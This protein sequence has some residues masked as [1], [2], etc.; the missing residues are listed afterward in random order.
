MSLQPGTVI[1]AQVQQSLATARCRSRAAAVDRRGCRFRCRP[2]K[3]CSYRFR[4]R[5]TAASSSLVNPARRG[6]SDYRRSGQRGPTA[7]LVALNPARSPIS[8]AN[9][10]G[11]G[12]ST[13]S[14][15]ATG[16]PAV[17]VAAQAAATQQTSLAPSCRPQRGCRWSGL[18]PQVQQ[19]MAQVLAQRTSL[20]QTDR[21][22][23]RAGVPEFG[24][25]LEASLA[26]GSA[27]PSAAPDFKAALIVLRQVLTTSLGDAAP[28]PGTT[29][30]TAT[31]TTA[32]PGSV[33][34]GEDTP[35]AVQVSSLPLTIIAEPDTSNAI[36]PA[37]APL[38]APE[39]VEP[40]L[41]Q[42]TASPP[43]PGYPTSARRTPAFVPATI[44]AAR[45]HR[46][47]RCRPQPAAG[48]GAGGSPE[49]AE[50]VKPRV[51]RGPT[52]SGCRR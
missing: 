42:G 48:S 4:R 47:Q 45:A 23:H 51:R 20:D 32:Q 41:L 12:R 22:R 28:T 8:G 38:L 27:P 18:P 14:A 9:H 13:Q 16:S 25:F 6:S 2:V 24:L 34:P 21:R 1:S 35:A 44:A 33:V 11:R 3:R 30:S 49:F 50:F 19:A 31:V 39:T 52:M 17:S 36:S 29:T 43:L 46:G 7:D 40:V 5:L 26:S 10:G 37:L 15:H